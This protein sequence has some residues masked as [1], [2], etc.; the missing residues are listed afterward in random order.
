MWLLELRTDVVHP[1]AVRPWL[2][3]ILVGMRGL[4]VVETC[5]TELHEHGVVADTGPQT[6]GRVGV[7]SA[8]DVPFL[9]R[10][11]R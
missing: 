7:F 2:S 6:D 1:T 3:Y 4:L 8:Q 11:E 5:C 10:K 9:F